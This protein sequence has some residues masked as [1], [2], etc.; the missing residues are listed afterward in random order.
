[1]LDLFFQNAA[2]LDLNT[3]AAHSCDVGVSE[4]KIVLVRE[5]RDDAPVPESRSVVSCAGYWLFPGFLDLHTHLFAHGFTYPFQ[6]RCIPGL[7]QGKLHR[8]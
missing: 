1:M 7:G 2:C 8:K 5:H 3:G 4:G 6:K